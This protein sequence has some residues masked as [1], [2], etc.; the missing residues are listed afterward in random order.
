MK[1]SRRHVLVGAGLVGCRSEPIVAPRGADAR[2]ASPDPPGSIGGMERRRGATVIVAVVAIAVGVG[3]GVYLW[4]EASAT[5]S[6]EPQR[7]GGVSDAGA[8]ARAGRGK[9]KPGKRVA[10]RG[11]RGGA[12]ARPKPANGGGNNADNGNADDVSD[13]VED[14]HPPF[15]GRGPAGP[16]YEAAIATNTQEITI[17]AQG[18]RDLTDPQLSR[19]MGD[20]AFVGECGARTP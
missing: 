9:A 14:V 19:P 7:D 17:G 4:R 16:T 5:N 18:E 15:V 10:G 11:A 12:Q 3:G 8:D 20:G 13:E 2:G 6:D 1:L